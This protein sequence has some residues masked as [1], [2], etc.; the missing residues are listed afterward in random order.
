MVHDKKIEY[1][2]NL[3]ERK[4]LRILGPINDNG[5][6]RIRYNKEMYNRYGDLEL[7]T[8]IKLGRACAK[9]G[10]PKCT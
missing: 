5:M 6:W 10:K 3:Y 8:V 4:I 7:S 9:D 1:I 2:I